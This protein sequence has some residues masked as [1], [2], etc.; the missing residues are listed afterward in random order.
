M[1]YTA[2]THYE[3]YETVEIETVE[4]GMKLEIHMRQGKHAGK[5]FYFD[6]AIVYTDHFTDTC[7]LTVTKRDLVKGL[8]EIRDRNA[9]PTREY[10]QDVGYNERDAAYRQYKTGEL[11]ER[12]YLDYCSDSYKRQDQANKTARQQTKQ[13]TPW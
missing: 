7:G 6:V 12:E 2:P 13:P 3:Q 8:A 4:T 9:I 1:K 11:S 5:E 10:L